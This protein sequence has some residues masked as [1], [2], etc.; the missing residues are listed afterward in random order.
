[1]ALTTINII[2]ED[3]W[4]L[5]T[6]EM[7]TGKIW[8]V[9]VSLVLDFHAE[10][11]PGPHHRSGGGGHSDTFMPGLLPHQEELW[12]RC[13]DDL[14]VPQRVSWPLADFVTFLSLSLRYQQL[15]SDPYYLFLL[16]QRVPPA[17][18]GQESGPPQGAEGQRQ[19]LGVSGAQE[20]GAVWFGLSPQWTDLRGEETG[21]GGLLQWG[22]VSAHLHLHPGCRGQPPC[23]QVSHWWSELLECT[24]W[25]YLAT[26]LGNPARGDPPPTWF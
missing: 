22:P 3:F 17:Q 1:M 5:A 13:R 20:D 16:F 15:V 24:Y 19:R 10:N 12:E 7:L 2:L 8:I 14:Q 9:C 11:G 18:G 6:F 25:C 26:H 4:L 21:G 23:S